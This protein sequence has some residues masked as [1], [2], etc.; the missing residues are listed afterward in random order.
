MDIWEKF[1]S[2]IPISAISNDM[3]GANKR[4]L[5]SFVALACE[6]S[7]QQTPVARLFMNDNNNKKVWISIFYV[8]TKL[9]FSNFKL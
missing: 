5:S 7:T 8:R 3:G 6:A 1:I 4:R 9:S 2:H